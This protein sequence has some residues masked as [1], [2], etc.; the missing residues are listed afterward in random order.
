M[1]QT[2]D[3]RPGPAPT[4]DQLGNYPDELMIDWGDTPA[5]SVASIYWPAVNSADVLALAKQLY[6][7]HQLSAAD[8]HTITVRRAGRLHFGPDPGRAPA[9][10]SPACSP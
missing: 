9:P 5:G 3:I 10:T 7:T 6:S 2:F 1:P 4:N 8:V